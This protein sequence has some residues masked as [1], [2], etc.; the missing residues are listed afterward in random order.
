MLW[1]LTAT[2]IVDT[3]ILQVISVT[4]DNASNNDIMLEKLEE[5]FRRE[6]IEFDASNARI[7][8]MPHSLH[9]A[10]LKVRLI[11]SFLGFVITQFHFKLLEAPGIARGSSE[12]DITAYADMYPE[13][14]AESVSR[15]D[16]DSRAAN[17]IEDNGRG[18]SAI[19]TVRS[20]SS[21]QSYFLSN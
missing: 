1:V 15:V 12:D 14:E 2:S 16:E 4:C 3:W 8:C 11:G 13:S 6:D 20:H 21:I 9:L 18:W 5:R 19:K 10:A 17:V 7:R